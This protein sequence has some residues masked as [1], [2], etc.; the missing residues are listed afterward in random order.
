MFFGK[1]KK[2][3]V[4]FLL[5]SQDAD[6][7][8]AE[9]GKQHQNRDPHIPK[10]AHNAAAEHGDGEEGECLA[11]GFSV[12]NRIGDFFLMVVVDQI[13]PASVDGDTEI[14]KYSSHREHND[15]VYQHTVTPSNSR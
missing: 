10:Q 7:T 6:R 12:G 2:T 8:D 4:I 15:P 5:Y 11:E 3:V 14:K 1:S 9:P 13:G